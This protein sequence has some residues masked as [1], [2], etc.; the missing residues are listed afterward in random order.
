M[1]N[2][3]NNPPG[4][5]L[6]FVN[7]AISCAGSTNNRIDEV[8]LQ[9]LNLE[10]DD[11]TIPRVYS[12]LS[13][14]CDL[15]DETESMI[16]SAIDEDRRELYLRSL[17]EIRKGLLPGNLQSNWNQIE[18]YFSKAALTGL[19]FCA[20]D[21]PKEHPISQDEI[22]SVYTELDS[23]FKS[24]HESK[25]NKTL[26]TWLLTLLSNA[27]LSIDLYRIKGARAFKQALRE[28]VGEA[29]LHKDA[30]PEVKRESSVFNQLTTFLGNLN[31]LAQRAEEWKPLLEYSAAS[32]SSLITQL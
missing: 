16:A 27:K 21:L 2:S 9:V 23:L 1:P 20:A 32:V 25:L 10:R 11:R 26:K 7:E 19:E 15:L 31:T 6:S 12:H 3:Y 5:L 22:K 24:V 13:L 4:R 17:P 14:M 18:K 29:V 8:W 30:F 28:M